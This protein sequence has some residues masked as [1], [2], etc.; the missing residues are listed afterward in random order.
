MRGYVTPIYPVFLLR[1]MHSSFHEIKKKLK[2]QNQLLRPFK[3]LYIFLYAVASKIR[4]HSESMFMCPYSYFIQ[5]HPH[6]IF[7]QIYVHTTH[8]H[9]HITSLH[10]LVWRKKRT[11]HTTHSTY[12]RMRKDDCTHYIFFLLDKTF[13]MHI[14]K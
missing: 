13:F 3:L 5:S 6:L 9:T 12:K 11:R 14:K 10:P 1:F 4:V 7:L 8:I 2:S